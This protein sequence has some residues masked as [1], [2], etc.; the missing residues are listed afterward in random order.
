MSAIKYKNFS[1]IKGP[2]G[3]KGDTGVVKGIGRIVYNPTNRT[4]AFDSNGLATTAYVDQAIENVSVDLTGYAT[5]TYVNT[6]INNLINGAPEI[7]DTLGEIANQLNNDGSLLNAVLNQINGKLNILG[8]TLTGSLILHADPIEN[9]QAAT[10]QYVD[11]AVSSIPVSLDELSNVNITNLSAGQVLKYNGTA[12]VNGADNSGLASV[13]WADISSKPNFA[14]VATSGNYNDLT[15]KPSIPSFNQSLNTTNDVTFNSINAK[16]IDVESLEFTGTGPIAISSGNDLNFNAAGDIKFNG[17]KLAR[18]A[19]T[20]SYNDLTDKPTLSQQI[21]VSANGNLTLVNGVISLP[22]DDTL[23]AGSIRARYRS[24]VGTSGFEFIADDAVLADRNQTP[25]SGTRIKAILGYQNEDDLVGFIDGMELTSL[26]RIDLSAGLIQINTDGGNR[27]GSI[28]MLSSDINI[29]SMSDLPIVLDGGIEVRN[30]GIKFND[31]SVQTKAFSGSYN[32]L[33]NKP[34]I[35]D[36]L[37]DLNITDGEFGQVLT[38]DGSGNFYFDDLSSS[39]VDVNIVGEE[40]VFGADL[41]GPVSTTTLLHPVATSGNYNALNN[42]PTIPTAV[43]QLA[44]DSGFISGVAWADVQG[45]PEFSTVAIT[46]DY[47]NL[48]NTPVIPRDIAQ[49]SD[50]TGILVN[51]ISVAT[52]KSIVNDSVDFAD[53]KARISNL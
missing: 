20:G 41:L 29:G 26:G 4:I 34:A 25:T 11:N 42:L 35:P 23:V 30:G 10:K 14:A 2:K 49:L 48:I 12:W 47:E 3:D 17:T 39:V 45:K 8:G 40:I 5:E 19:N 22:N 43:S 13:S 16:T 36:N 32:D 31:G 24:Y 1:Y 15:N 28:L 53:F 21:S 38:T 7:L 51:V 33:T 9:L 18:V 50:N 52:L 27:Q 46:A 44:N 37:Q 6:A